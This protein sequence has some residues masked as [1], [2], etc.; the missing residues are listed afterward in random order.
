M[1]IGRI[2]SREV[3]LAEPRECAQVAAA[4]MNARNVGSLIVI[5]ELG[6]PVGIVTD[7]DLAIKVLAQGLDPFRTLVGDVMSCCP[8]AVEEETSIEAAIAMMRS[9]PFRRLPVVN[10]DGRLVGVLSVDDILEILSDE[11]SQIGLLLRRENPAVLAS[12]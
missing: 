4:R 9:G 1:T 5:N 7:R 8:H 10:A 11:F 6:K 12:Y 3:D 2:C